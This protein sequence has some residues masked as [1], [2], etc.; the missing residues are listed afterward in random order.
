MVINV[1]ISMGRLC[2]FKY[3]GWVVMPLNFGFTKFIKI[4][5]ASEKIQQNTQKL[6]TTWICFKKS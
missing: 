4:N 6:K 2:G 1:Y 3:L 5:L